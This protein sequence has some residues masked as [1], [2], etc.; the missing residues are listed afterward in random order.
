[1]TLSKR[2]K[3][4]FA[5]LVLF[6]SSCMNKK[7]MEFKHILDVQ[8]RKVTQMLIG[9]KGSESRK[10]NY[11]IADDFDRALNVVNEQEREFDAVLHALKNLDTADLEKAIE[12]QNEA[13][14]YYDSLKA[15]HMYAKK[16]IAQQ[17]VISTTNGAERDRAQDELMKLAKN[18][19]AMYDDVYRNE[20]S[21]HDTLLEFEEGNGLR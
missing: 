12:L 3:V 1:M 9:K 7:A 21:L 18:K 2:L 11:L 20:K 15:L 10:L 19:Q 5:G 6:L 4:F 13:I 8:E 17:K 14:N 16:E